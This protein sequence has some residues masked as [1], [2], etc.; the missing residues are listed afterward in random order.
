MFNSG[1]IEGLPILVMTHVRVLL[2]EVVEGEALVSE[3]GWW[4]NFN[5]WPLVKAWLE[6]EILHLLD[7]KMSAHVGPSWKH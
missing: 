4:K 2:I 1:G 3:N 7:Y 5:A 6:L